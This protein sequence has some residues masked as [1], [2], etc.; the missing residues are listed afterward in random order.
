MAIIIPTIT[1]H[2]EVKVIVQNA[3]VSIKF[4]SL[5]ITDIGLGNNK[6]LSIN[7]ER[8]SHISTQNMA[9]IAFFK[10]LFINVVEIVIRQFISNRRGRYGCHS[11]KKS[12][13]I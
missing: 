12:V 1:R 13:H 10:A 6:L 2:K 11:G 5:V 3:D 8:I 4:T 9:I 7:N